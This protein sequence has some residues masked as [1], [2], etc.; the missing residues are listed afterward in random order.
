METAAATLS[1]AAARS[2]ADGER[3]LHL[4]GLLAACESCED[5][6]DTSG[7]VS[8]MSYGVGPPKRS[9][10]QRSD[11]LTVTVPEHLIALC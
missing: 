9:F 7:T 8:F 1:A 5:G 3:K 6:K 4:S 10:K 2:N 11:C